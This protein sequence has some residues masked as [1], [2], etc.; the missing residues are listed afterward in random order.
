MNLKR[1][2]NQWFISLN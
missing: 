1:I 2:W